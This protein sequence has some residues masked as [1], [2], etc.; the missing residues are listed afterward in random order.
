MRALSALMHSNNKLIS[1]NSATELQHLAYAH[2]DGSHV[3]RITVDRD[4]AGEVR[5]ERN[6]SLA[7]HVGVNDFSQFVD[8]LVESKLVI[9]GLPISA[10]Y[11]YK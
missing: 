2:C 5:V 4:E 11:L 7:D 6:L 10:F 9:G 8:E 3:T 1:C